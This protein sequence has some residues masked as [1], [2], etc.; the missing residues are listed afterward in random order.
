MKSIV[1]SIPM[2]LMSMIVRGQNFEISFAPAIN[3]IWHS[4]DLT[5]LPVYKSRAGFNAGIHIA[6][7]VEKKLTLRYGLTYQHSKV[8]V[9]PFI[10][11]SYDPPPSD[12]TA[13]ILSLEI[14]ANLNFKHNFYLSFGPTI[15]LQLANK[16]DN[17]ESQTG[18]GLITGFGK[19]FK[20]N[21]KLF[22]NVRPNMGLR[23][24][25]TMEDENALKL[26]LLTAGLNIGIV[27]SNARDK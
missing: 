16:P 26:R 14:D 24:I 1:L 8:E 9:D 18:V 19:R 22:L 10:D 20:L 12:A 13:D 15:D 3:D 25:I 23:N 7:S 11:P 5:G 21:E 4:P 27:F 6:R 17:L 2:I